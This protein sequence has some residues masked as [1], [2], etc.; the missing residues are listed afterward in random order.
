MHHYEQIARAA[1]GL[2]LAGMSFHHAQRMA[3]HYAVGVISSTSGLSLELV[4]RAASAF[5]GLLALFFL[6]HALKTLGV[7]DEAW[8]ICIAVFLLNPYLFRYYTV[9]PGMIQDQLFIAAATGLVWAL[10][11]GSLAGA[12]VAIAVAALGRQTA[13]MILP[14]T[15][16]WMFAGE[17]WQE[18]QIGYRVASI[19]FIL[20]TAMGIYLGTQKFVAS[21]S[22]PSRNLQHVFGI[23]EWFQWAEASASGFFELVLRLFMPYVLVG[24][25]SVIALIVALQRKIADHLR[26]PELAA[27]VLGMVGVSAQPFLAG[28]VITGQN[29]SRLSALGFVFGVIAF[30]WIAKPLK[31]LGRREVAVVVGGSLIASFHH[32]YSGVGPRDALQFVLLQFSVA[33][34]LLLMGLWCFRRPSVHA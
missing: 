10:A 33:L 4:Y 17:R 26:A 19:V 29:A 24:S 1:P 13:L 30:G 5:L 31:E 28:P 16:V 22:E 9:V 12:A 18:K 23:F 2:P 7:G 25:L 8:R 14:A 27:C 15:A 34:G 32:L 6:S 11:S 21:F 3:P 20:V